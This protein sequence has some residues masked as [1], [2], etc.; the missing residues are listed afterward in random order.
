M[1]LSFQKSFFTIGTIFAFI[2]AL[3]LA[4]S[5]FIP[6]AFAL[7]IAFIL[8]PVC[9]KIE[10]WGV[11]KIL[12]VFLS[13]F[14]L[15][16]IIAGIIFIF[17][18]RIVNISEEFTEFRNQLLKLFADITVYI[19][20]NIGFVD[21]LEHG[22]LYAKLK[23]W[24]NESTGTLL[25]KTF[26]GTSNFLFGLM[27]AV[28]FSFLILLYRKGLVNAAVHFYAQENR[29]QALK[30]FQSVQKVGQKYLSG[31]FF[32]IFIIG[33]LNSLGLWIIGIDHPILF[34]F[35]AA[36]MSIVPYAGALIGASIPVLYGFMTEDSIWMPITIAIY[37]WAVQVLE[38]NFL[39]PK[40]VGTNLKLNA[41]NTILS[42][43]IGSSVWGVA[44]MIL[45]LPFTA[46]F[47]VVCQEYTVLKPVALLMGDSNYSKDKSNDKS[48]WFEKV[49][50]WF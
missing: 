15:F 45:F 16:L 46:M 41:L 31:M 48:K 36:L 9:R 2:A 21:D 30:M 12:A 39:T 18:N 14:T 10:T 25:S 27:I 32:V 4:K 43:I 47:K 1:H 13:I 34:G 23:T 17:S 37:F 33:V 29:S 24:L 5:I 26:S 44:G 50:S 22:E 35:L 40:I 38:S 42:I 28:V 49:K 6:L 19:N 8:F 3:I 11:S 7:L 20:D